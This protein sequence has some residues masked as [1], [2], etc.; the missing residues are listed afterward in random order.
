MKIE[1]QKAKV[2]AKQSDKPITPVEA[3]KKGLRLREIDFDERSEVAAFLVERI[4][5]DS[6]RSNMEAALNAAKGM[7]DLILNQYSHYT[8]AE[9]FY[10]WQ[11]YCKKE[12]AVEAFGVLGTPLLGAILDEYKTYHRGAHWKMRELKRAQKREAREVEIKA[13]IERRNHETALNWIALV[14]LNYERYL[15][16]NPVELKLCHYN[17][18]RKIGIYSAL[19]DL[20]ELFEKGKHRAKLIKSE[21]QRRQRALLK[22]EPLPKVYSKNELDTD[23]PPKAAGDVERDNLNEAVKLFLERNATIQEIAQSFLLDTI[24]ERAKAKGTSPENFEAYLM[25]QY[26]LLR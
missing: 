6:G 19:P 4:I 2:V 17:F 16:D 5:A 10:A 14:V 23:Q 24:F 11:L 3:A 9:I 21:M 25:K 12:I 22:N 18:L 7:R 1:K 8:A 13:E 15:A 20:D 26:N